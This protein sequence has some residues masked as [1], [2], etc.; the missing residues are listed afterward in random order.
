MQKYSVFLTPSGADFAYAADLI[1]EICGKYD[2]P[3]FEPHV[4]A[5]SGMF[6]DQ[7]A[8]EKAVSTA[9]AGVRPF[10]LRIRRIGCSNEYL[11][12]LF[13]EFE[14][15]PVLRGIYERIRAGVEMASGYDLFPHL[16]LLYI[17]MP[18]RDKQALAKRV[19]P[20]RD[21]IYFDEVKIV[22]PRN[23]KEGWRDTRQWQ[24]LL[25]MGL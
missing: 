14:E 8:L 11:K 4:T 20:D 15:D 16:S 21:L 25:R 2:V 13:I 24:T 17:D 12:S 1:R 19:V 22:T 23:L 7:D 10:S 5:Y 3:P 18:L 6:S 9:V